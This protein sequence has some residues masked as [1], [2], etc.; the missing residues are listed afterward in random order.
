MRK[1]TQLVCSHALEIL[2]AATAVA[3]RGVKARQHVLNALR[4]DLLDVLLPELLLCLTLLHKE[5]PA[6]FRLWTALLTPLLDAL[7][8]FNRATRDIEK[9]DLDDLGWPG[10]VG[11]LTIFP[12]NGSVVFASKHLMLSLYFLN[13]K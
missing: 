4:G 11:K 10:V 3:A 9:E 6:R 8:E 2:P 7:N 13:C 12:L 5:P 1:Y